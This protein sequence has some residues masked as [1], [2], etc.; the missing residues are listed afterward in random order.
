MLSNDIVGSI[1]FLNKNSIPQELKKDARESTFA[2]V[3]GM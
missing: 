2:S 3:I 1:I